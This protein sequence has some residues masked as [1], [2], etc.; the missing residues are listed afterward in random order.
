MAEYWILGAANYFRSKYTQMDCEGVGNRNRCML[1]D[2]PLMRITR[3]G[4]AQLR[5]RGGGEL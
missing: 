1:L 2:G 3:R 5:V 4:T